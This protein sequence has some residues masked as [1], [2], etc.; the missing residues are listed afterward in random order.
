MKLGNIFGTA[1]QWF[2][3]T[4]E[5]AL[6]QAYKA[7]LKIKEV[8]DN[9]FQGQKVLA[10]STDYGNSV[11]SYFQTEVKKQLKIIK[12]RLIEFNASR[13]I[14]ILSEF[15]RPVLETENYDYS[16]DNL[17]QSSIIIKKLNFIDEVK[18]RYESNISNDDQFSNGILQSSQESIKKSTSSVMGDSYNR[19]GQKDMSNRK[20]KIP[21]S[22]ES[23]FSEKNGVE[24]VSDKMGVLPRSFLNT[25]GRIRQEITPESEE[26]EEEVLKKYRKSRYKT[27]VSI[28]FVL[29]IIIVPLLIHQL[30]KTFFLIPVVESYFDKNDQV[31]FI[32]NDLQEEA[33]VELQ[34]FEETLRFNGLIGLAPKLSPE[35][36][37]QVVTNKAQEISESYRNRGINSVS[38]VFADI[39][40]L[41]AFTLVILTNKK[42]VIILK[43]FLDEVLYSLSDSAKAFLIILFTDMFVGFHSPHG[44]EVILEN[45]TQHFG[46]PENR[47]F[48]FLFIATFPVILDTIFKYWIF[49]YLNRLSP[50]AVAT[51]KNM[52]E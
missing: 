9:H 16:L 35:E 44:W 19:L 43:S 47:D 29:L 33:L 1:R 22:R 24:T 45:I 32:N 6:D 52:N 30:T 41:I 15:K 21:I 39:F 11:I 48:N 42:E 34:R 38:N 5:R 2:Y 7:A 40:S 31:I 28:K 50:S 13:S 49:R 51:Y 25:L 20:K 18:S 37:E 27:V 10:V 46:L 17:A 3:E 4:P 36:I 14:L 23:L 12:V 8:E 26:T